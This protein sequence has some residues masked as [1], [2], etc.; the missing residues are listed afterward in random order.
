MLAMNFLG[1]SFIMLTFDKGLKF[2]N[3]LYNS[4]YIIIIVLFVFFRFSGIV[5]KAQR[6]EEKRKAKLAGTGTTTTKVEKTD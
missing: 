2:T 3:S 4:I 6:L 1:T 5:K